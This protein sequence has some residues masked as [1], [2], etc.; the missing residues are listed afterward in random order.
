VSDGQ[1]E[2]RSMVYTEYFA[3]GTEPTAYCA[4][5]ASRGMITKLAGWFGSD[6]PPPLRIENQGLVPA[7][8]Y[9]GGPLSPLDE[10][11]QAA[12]AAATKKRRFW[13]RLFGKGGPP[14]D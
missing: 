11:S 6:G 14:E 5:H 7:I 9:A 12:Q 2:R 10:A 8:N 1:L 3:P 4:Q 13:S